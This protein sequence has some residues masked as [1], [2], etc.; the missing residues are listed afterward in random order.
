METDAYFLS[1][2]PACAV[3]ESAAVERVRAG[4]VAARPA[5]YDDVARRLSH[6]AER[7][8]APAAPRPAGP[9]PG[10]QV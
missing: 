2:S 4:L 3:L 8:V 9:G 1:A 6:A 5:S 7:A 10:R